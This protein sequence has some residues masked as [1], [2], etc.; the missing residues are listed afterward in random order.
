AIAHDEAAPVVD[1]NIERVLARIFAV[2][3]P[4]PAA[5]KIIRD[6]QAKLTPSER[7]GDYA[8]ALMDLGATICT[9][10]RPACRLCPWSETCLARA[11]GTQEAYPVK[12][13]KTVRPTR[14]GAA[15]V[16]IRADGAVLLRQRP[17]TGL[18]GG[19]AEP[20]GTEW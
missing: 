15:F 12:T 7:P 2:E 20:P 10:K 9:Q 16:A 17:E 5:K 8:Q 14:H 1:G 18:L 6:L 4:L 13:M 11:G 19:M 3:T